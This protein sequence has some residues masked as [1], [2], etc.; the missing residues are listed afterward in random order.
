MRAGPSPFSRFGF[1]GDE[2][3]FDIFWRGLHQILKFEEDEKCINPS[4]FVVDTGCAKLM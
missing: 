4:E 2:E 3:I 1:A